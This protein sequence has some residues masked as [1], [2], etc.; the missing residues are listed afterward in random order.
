MVSRARRARERCAGARA[1]EARDE[2]AQGADDAAGDCDAARG[3]RVSGGGGGASGL[4]ARF[5]QPHRG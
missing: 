1:T 2:L 3:R 5:S 4:A